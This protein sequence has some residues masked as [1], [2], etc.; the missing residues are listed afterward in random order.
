MLQVHVD[1]PADVIT[2][3]QLARRAARAAGFS[4]R[5]CAELMIVA[6]ELAS[7]VLK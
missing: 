6:S 7:N 4:R 2:S 5:A 1:H 3:Q